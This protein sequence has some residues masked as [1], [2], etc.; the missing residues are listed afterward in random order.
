MRAMAMRQ[1]E[2]CKK[3][4]VEKYPKDAGS[5]IEQGYDGPLDSDCQWS[6]RTMEANCKRGSVLLSC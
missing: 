2:V 4:I 6:M 5:A 1:I 3:D